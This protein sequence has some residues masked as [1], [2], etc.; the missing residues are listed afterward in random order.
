[1]GVW[2]G[3]VLVLSLCYLFIEGRGMLDC[4][5]CYCILIADSIVPR[6]DIY[7][8]KERIMSTS[9]HRATYKLVSCITFAR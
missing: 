9:L 7:D 2:E 3:G 1:M 6:L 5:V 4:L 8:L